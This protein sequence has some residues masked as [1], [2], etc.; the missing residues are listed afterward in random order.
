MNLFKAVFS[1]YYGFKEEFASALL[2]YLL[3]PDMDH[4]I[5]TGF[6]K[7]FLKSL[8]SVK[9]PLPQKLI[10]E[11]S[12]STLKGDLCGDGSSK[13]KVNVEYEECDICVR[14]E[15]Q[16]GKILLVVENK[17]NP[18]SVGDIITQ[19]NGYAKNISSKIGFVHENCIKICIL[20]DTNSVNRIYKNG[21]NDIYFTSWN[22]DGESTCGH[23]PIIDVL[24]RLLLESGDGTISP[25]PSD[26]EHMIKSLIN[27]ILDGFSGYVNMA[28]PKN[29]S[30]AEFV[31]MMSNNIEDKEAFEEKAERIIKEIYDSCDSQKYTVPP[32]GPI[33]YLQTNSGIHSWPFKINSNGY[34]QIQHQAI[35]KLPLGDDPKTTIKEWLC[36]NNQDFTSSMGTSFKF[37]FD[38]L[39]KSENLAHFKDALARIKNL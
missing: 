14:I 12:D 29:M 28:S 27:F 5:K 31:K 8:R 7:L 13:I 22:G 32:N 23:E 39:F 19:I 4:A 3:C 9:G 34:V 6:L 36:K 38:L 24:R 15:N 11:I 18:N 25:L 16:K 37:A 33:I 1:G 30:I 26:T 17:I 20:P 35:G 10:D 2:A 21:G